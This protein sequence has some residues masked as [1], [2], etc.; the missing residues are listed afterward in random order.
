M[1]CCIDC[2][3]SSTTLHCSHY[4]AGEPFW[5]DCLSGVQAQAGHVSKEGEKHLRCFLGSVTLTASLSAPAFSDLMGYPAH[6]CPAGGSQSHR[7]LCK[8]TRKHSVAPSCCCQAFTNLCLPASTSNDNSVRNALT[9][10]AV[11]PEG[12][13]LKLA[14]VQEVPPELIICGILLHICV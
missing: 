8:R 1:L 11:S 6:S 9:V 5:G 13:A 7:N 2:T 10:R 3:G 12:P 14:E 4:A